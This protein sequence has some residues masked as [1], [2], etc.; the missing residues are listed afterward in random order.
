[1]T[2]LPNFDKIDIRSWN[3]AKI[4]SKLSEMIVGEII[5]RANYIMRS[6]YTAFWVTAFWEAPKVSRVKMGSS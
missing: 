3:F 5:I 6:G 2:I 1:M 4:L